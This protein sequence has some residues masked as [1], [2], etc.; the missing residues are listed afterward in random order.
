[1][2]KTRLPRKWRRSY[3]DFFRKD[4]VPRDQASGTTAPVLDDLFEGY[5]VAPSANPSPRTIVFEKRGETGREKTH[6]QRGARNVTCADPNAAY[7]EESS[8]DHET[9][10]LSQ[11][12]PYRTR[13]SANKLTCITYARIAGARAPS[14]PS[15]FAKRKTK[16]RRVK[17]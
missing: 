13:L 16:S 17:V 14:R 15:Y 9:W 10:N 7:L 11:P 1:M 4:P 12:L 8:L 2:L 3:G 5:W 6:L